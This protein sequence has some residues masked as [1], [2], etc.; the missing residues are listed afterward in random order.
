[1]ISYLRNTIIDGSLPAVLAAVV[2]AGAAASLTS[3]AVAR[4]PVIL[5]YV[6]AASGS[7]RNA[8]SLSAAFACGVVASYII[9]GLLFGVVAGWSGTL[10]ALSRYLYSALGA[11][12]IAGGLLLAGLLPVG[13]DRGNKCCAASSRR[14][15]TLPSAFMLGM[16][17][18]VLELPACPSCGAVFVIIASLALIKGSILYSGLIFAGFAVGQ[19]LPVLAIGL[20]AGV[21]KQLLPRASGITEAVN[22][23]SGNA[24][25]GSG[26]FLLLIA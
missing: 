26:L 16:V 15:K 14:A 3:C 5:G 13:G 21:M 23:A 22:F 6:T 12:L 2:F 1:M 19:S 18:T 25:L 4:L 24:L 10:I 20:C 17:F 7:K 11:L 8:F 9:L